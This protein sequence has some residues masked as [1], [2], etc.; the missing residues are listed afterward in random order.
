M[1]SPE[2][3]PMAIPMDRQ[4]LRLR[5]VDRRFDDAAKYNK[6]KKKT[7]KPMATLRDST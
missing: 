4:S 2:P 6:K 5:H 1:K 7:Y 3:T